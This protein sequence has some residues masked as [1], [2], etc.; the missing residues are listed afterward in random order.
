MGQYDFAEEHKRAKFSYAPYQSYVD[1]ICMLVW[2]SDTLLCLGL[3]LQDV[4]SSTVPDSQIIY[5]KQFV[6]D[7]SVRCIQ[8]GCQFE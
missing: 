3:D 8:A 5:Q 7:S 2:Y 6:A 4:C 1:N